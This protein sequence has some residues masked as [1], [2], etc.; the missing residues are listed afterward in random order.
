MSS[1]NYEYDSGARYPIKTWTRGVPVED[2]A[3]AQLRNIAN[4]PFIHKH[5]AGMPD[6]H[7][8]KGATVGSV[9][10]TKK[11]IMPASV[12]V[13]IG[14]GVAAVRTSLHA[15]DLPD[16]LHAV[17]LAIEAA[18]PHGGP[19]V[20][21]SWAELGRGGAPQDVES[22][23]AS[24]F[25][26]PYK[27]LLGKHPK[28]A[29]RG[30]ITQLGSLGGGNHFLEVCLDEEGYV[31]A[32][33]HSGSRGMGNKIG[34]YFI[35]RA[36]ELMETMFIEL[37]DSDLA[38]L[39]EAHPLFGDYWDGLALAQ[40]YAQANRDVM[41]GRM[42][43]A[44]SATLPPFVLTHEAINNHHNYVA[45]ENHFG[46]NVWVTRKGAVRARK[47]DLG[48][49]PG[50]MGTG[51]FI[52][53]GKGNADSFCSCSHGAGRKMSRR[54]ARRTIS[55][56]DH[57][58]AMQGIEARL[59]EGVLDESPA[60]YKDIDAVMAAQGDLVEVVYRLRQIVNVKG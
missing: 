29:S 52:V 34:S 36:K 44:L 4:M 23:W 20:K 53:R 12:G 5:V 14:C 39:P 6:M 19:G 7:L 11:A 13:D 26:Q 18:V 48:V 3:R 42:L 35:D 27:D 56:E 30:A 47:D 41:M 21:G 33:L 51:S 38:Y 25:A 57:V 46:Q 1:F 10:A 54:Q 28:A 45:K 55:L 40:D 8:G 58:T 16:N 32:M 15:N 24:E 17:R 37:E 50:S 43:D 49:I 31:W 60:A 9:I 59:D 2:A 22:L